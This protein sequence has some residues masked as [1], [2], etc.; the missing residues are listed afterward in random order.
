MLIQHPRKLLAT[1]KQCKYS[2][3]S[4]LKYIHLVGYRNH[5]SFYGSQVSGPTPPQGNLKGPLLP[6]PLPLPL[7]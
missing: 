3:V 1:H 6:P 4:L 5:D 7:L 2:R